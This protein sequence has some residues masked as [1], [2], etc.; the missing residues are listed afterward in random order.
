M[1]SFTFIHPANYIEAGI[2]VGVLFPLLFFTK[3]FMLFFLGLHVSILLLWQIRNLKRY[4]FGD[5]K[6]YLAPLDGKVCE[7]K[8]NTSCPYL[9]GVWKCISIKGGIGDSVLQYAPIEG[10]I[11]QEQLITTKNIIFPGQIKWLDWMIYHRSLLLV[12]LKDMVN[13]T[14]CL[15]ETFAPNH[16]PKMRSIQSVG[17]TFPVNRA[18]VIGT[19]RGL[20]NLLGNVLSNL[21]IPVHTDIQVQVGQTV[22]A[23]ET[24]IARELDRI[25]LSDESIHAKN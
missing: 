8:H 18:S 13:Q 6:E 12:E 24:V 17:I 23:G 22:V 21:Y 14:R 20:D 25:L 4:N 3:S 9:D 10:A 19:T 16:L 11:V 5:V 15:V 1:I 2:L 7:I